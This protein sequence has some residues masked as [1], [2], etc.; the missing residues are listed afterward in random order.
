MRVLL[1]IVL[2]VAF[3][4]LSA[5]PQTYSCRDGEGRM[6]FSDN[7]QGLPEECIG[8]EKTI[9]PGSADNLNFVPATPQPRGASD[10]FKRSVQSAEQALQQKED[11]EQ[12]LQ[13]RAEELLQ[14]YQQAVVEKRQARRS[15]DYG[16]REIVK[17]AD[18]EMAK[19]RTG[20]QELLKE[21]AGA[22]ISTEEK[23]KIR[24]TLQG[25][26]SE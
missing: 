11:L 10:E 20:K 6:H 4:V 14:S 19:A 9:K 24:Q 22:R 3:S 2:M 23:D 12:Q 7:L 16:S 26:E 17:K 1:L 21:L 13:S 18:E 15:W 5:W 8:K 25:I